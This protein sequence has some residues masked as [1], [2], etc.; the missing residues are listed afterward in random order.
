[1]NFPR[2][3]S[4]NTTIA[5]KI[6]LIFLTEGGVLKVSMWVS[7][8]DTRGNYTFLPRHNEVFTKVYIKV[9]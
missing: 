8:I 6:S 2:V 1:M 3:R 5:W 7:W 4:F 9:E